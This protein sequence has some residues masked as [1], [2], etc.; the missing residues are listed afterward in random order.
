MRPFFLPY[1]SEINEIVQKQTLDVNCLQFGLLSNVKN[2]SLRYGAH[3][4]IGAAFSHFSFECSKGIS[5]AC[6]LDRLHR[7]LSSIG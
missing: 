1:T 5:V 7:S 2:A 3:A 6:I 4:N